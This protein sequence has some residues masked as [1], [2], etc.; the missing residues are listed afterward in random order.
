MKFVVFQALL[1][2]QLVMTLI[3]VSVIQK[4]SPHYSLARWILCSTGLI[5]YL[6][7]TD[8]E[9]KAL[10]GKFRLNFIPIF[11]D[12]N[13]LISG[14]PKS[15]YKTKK[16]HRNKH[17]NY[18]NDEKSNTFH[19]PRNLDIQLEVTKVTPFDVMNLRYFTEY[20]WL[21]DF[22]L[23][24]LIIYVLSEIYHFYIPLREE[25]NLSMLWCFLVIFFAMWDKQFLRILFVTLPTQF[26]IP[27]N[28]W[29]RWPCSISEAKNQLANDQRALWR[30]SFICWFQ[31]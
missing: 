18:H 21:V 29:C 10:A 27:G 22:S 17:N 3:M 11:I 31:W 1:G 19:V 7:P 4:L 15:V 8:T 26:L 13:R 6:H 14:V 30:D 2:A 5:R 24:T 23:Y 9:L 12:Y 16:D 20:Q 25:V 28:F